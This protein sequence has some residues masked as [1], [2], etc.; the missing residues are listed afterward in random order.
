MNAPILAIFL[1]PLGYNVEFLRPLSQ[2][3]RKIHPAT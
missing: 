1:T 3:G 2:N